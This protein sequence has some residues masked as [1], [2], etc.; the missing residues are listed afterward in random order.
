[1]AKLKFAELCASANTLVLLIRLSTFLRR[2]YSGITTARLME[3][4]PGEKERVTDRGISRIN[5]TLQFNSK[6]QQAVSSDRKH[7]DLGILLDQCNEFRR[8]YRD[9][10]LSEISDSVEL[11]K[12]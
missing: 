3:Y 10:D 2:A 12:S 6:F 11:R 1:L 4:H 5:D 9:Y 8:S 7:I